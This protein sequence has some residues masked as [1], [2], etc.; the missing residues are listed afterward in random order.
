MP[1][2]S[3]VHEVAV[4]EDLGQGLYRTWRKQPTQATGAGFWFDLSMS[5]GNPV[6][7]YYI[8]S[9]GVFTPLRQSIDGGIPH[10]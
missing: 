7:N 2:F 6:P 4:A 10:D 8:G 5:P 9:P 3:G 1:G